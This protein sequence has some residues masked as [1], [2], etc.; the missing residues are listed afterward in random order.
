MIYYYVMFVLSNTKIQDN[1]TSALY[2]EACHFILLTN[3]LRYITNL[4]RYIIL[5]III[6]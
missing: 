3:L 6:E 4:L 2:A 1:S 5:Y